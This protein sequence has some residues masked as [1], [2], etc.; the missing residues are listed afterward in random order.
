MLSFGRLIHRKTAEIVTDVD[1]RLLLNL[2]CW[3]VNALCEIA[4]ANEELWERCINE[5][6]GG[7]KYDVLVRVLL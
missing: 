7:N 5:L 4:E 6:K 3:E 2:V 1:W